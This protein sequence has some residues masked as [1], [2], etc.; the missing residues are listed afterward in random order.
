MIAY[1]ASGDAA[2]ATNFLSLQKSF[3]IKIHAHGEDVV[4]ATREYHQFKPTIA[5][6]RHKTE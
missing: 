5:R 2:V 3:I 1:P 6:D 4:S